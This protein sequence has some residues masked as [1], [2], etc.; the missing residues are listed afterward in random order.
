MTTTVSYRLI[1]Q[2]LDRQLELT[3]SRGAVKLESDYYLENYQKITSIDEFLNDTR[4]FNFA[5]N[6]FGLSDLAFA[7]GYMRKILEG[8]VVEPSA[9]ANRTN[10][11]R[12]TAFAETFDFAFWREETMTRSGTG[13]EVVDRYVRQSLEEDAGE[14][15]EGV[16]LAL[17]FERMAPQ[18]ESAYD[19]L[20]DAALVE[21]VLTALGLPSEFSAA[22]IDKQAAALEARIDFETLTE[23]E[24]LDRF[25]LQ[26]TALWEAENVA[27]RD[28]ILNLFGV[29]S[30]S[31]STVSLELALTFS[32]LRL[33]GN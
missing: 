25:L 27:A 24:E 13:Q 20:A 19:I 21:V 32:Q 16:R 28:P 22:D 2:N 4:V 30:S 8:G 26:F 6:A 14:S 9:L 3:A 1:S 33:G 17:Y 29:G 10:D 5:M 23:P 12:I 18:I 7:K 31:S 15:D 11:A